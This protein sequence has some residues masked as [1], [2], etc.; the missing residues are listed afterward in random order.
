MGLTFVP[1]SRFTPQMFLT[2]SYGVYFFFASLMIL[3]VAFVYFLVPE[4]KSLPL[5]S[6]DRLF[7]TKPVQKAHQ[8]VMEE[9]RV[10]DEEF[11]RN[12]EGVNLALDEKGNIDQVE[13]VD[14]V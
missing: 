6:M 7:E 8:I 14:V 3:S 13:R 4:T 5:E 9:L 10:K 1:V 11:R 12:T 2:M